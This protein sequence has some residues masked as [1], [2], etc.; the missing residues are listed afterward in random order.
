MKIDLTARRSLFHHKNM[1][2]RKVFF[3]ATMI[4][5]LLLTIILML[6]FSGCLQKIP[7]EPAQIEAFHERPEN[8]QLEFRNGKGRQVAFYIPPDNEPELPPARIA[9]LY[10]GIETVA[11]G[12]RRF[13]KL[14]EKIDTG[15]LLIDYPGRGFSEGFM[16]PEENYLNSEGALKALAE[17]FGIREIGAE[18]NLLGHS[19]GTGAALQ[20]ASR[21]PVKRI[22]LVAPFTTLRKA[23]AEKSIILSLLMPAQI[24]NREIIR[25]LLAA[26]VSPEITIFHGA[27]DTSLPVSMGRALAAIDPERIEYFELPEDDHVSLLTSRRDLIFRTLNGGT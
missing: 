3:A 9:I 8:V 22:V 1:A 15:Y 19:F 2:K 6:A 7:Y 21:H 5:N 12:W 20:F 14:E 24:D 10:P 26:E 16:H 17:H 4:R 13:I 11:L 25:K 27:R 18:L 23:V